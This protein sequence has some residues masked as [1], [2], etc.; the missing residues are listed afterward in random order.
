M[1]AVEGPRQ[2]ESAT[3]P[4]APSRPGRNGDSRRWTIGLLVA[5]G[6]LVTLLV[7]FFVSPFVSSSPDGLEKVAADTAIDRD[8]RDHA[9]ADGPLA[10]YSVRGIQDARL[11]TG[12]AG[13]V[14]VT[15]TFAIGSG[16]LLVVRRSGRRSGRR[17]DD[18]AVPVAATTGART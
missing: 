6:V 11:S 4:D 18:A 17:R 12:L 3:S 9:L 5:G 10:D 2:P 16:L 8:E 13:V 7:A 1:R 14:G 15:V